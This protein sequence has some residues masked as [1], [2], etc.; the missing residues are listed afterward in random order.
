MHILTLQRTTA[1]STTFRLP[2]RPP[3][4]SSLN[5]GKERR[6]PKQR[7]STHSTRLHRRACAR[8]TR[9]PART[10]SR[11]RRA[12]S[13]NHRGVRDS[14]LARRSDQV[15]DGG[16]GRRHAAGEGHGG[17]GAGARVGGGGAGLGGVGC[18]VVVGV[19]D[20]VDDL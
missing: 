11:G 18:G 20:G 19:Q 1:S 13:R 3:I 15:D 7:R 10:S 6:T 16:R 14:D 5:V 4:P 9:L 12:A 2:F 17:A 8:A